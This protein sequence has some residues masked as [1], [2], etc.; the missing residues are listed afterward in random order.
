[1]FFSSIKL[2]SILLQIHELTVFHQKELQ[3]LRV[4]YAMHNSAA[5]MAE[6]QSKVETQEVMLEHLKEQ[7]R[8]AEVERDQLSASK[9]RNSTLE[10]E[11][12]QVK[13]DL[14]E[15]RRC[16]APEMRHYHS[17]KCKI[18]EMEARHSQRERDLQ[19]IIKNSH[20]AASMEL[21][22][23]ADRWKNIIDAKNRETEKFRAELDSILDVLRELQRQ[24]VVIP[25]RSG[26]ISHQ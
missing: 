8:I 2:S 3:N 26:F 12:T 20:Q 16:H 25:Y 1:M 18:Q 10:T 13:D 21:S 23:E 5:Q 14:A 24:G 15:A 4:D 6:L 11:I 19:Q 7:V 22:E 9:Q 17:L